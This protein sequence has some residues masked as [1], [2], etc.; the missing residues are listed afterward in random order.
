[1]SIASFPSSETFNARHLTSIQVAEA[2]IPPPQFEQLLN[3][4]N[5]LLV[6]ARGS[7]KTTLLKML[8]VQAL[9]KWKE[10]NGFDDFPVNFLGVFVP[11]DVRWSKQLSI[12]TQGITS[13]VERAVLYE[14][15]FAG[16]VCIALIDTL[17]QAL[18]CGAIRDDKK[19]IVQITREQEAYISRAL[20]LLWGVVTDI[21]SFQALKL[22]LRYS[23]A[24]LPKIAMSLK[25]GAGV[26][27]MLSENG[28]LGIGWLDALANA[29]EIINECAGCN[30]QKWALLV[31]ELEIV[32]D[33]LLGLIA[34]PLRSTT[35]NLVFKY[36]I[37]PTGTKSEII[38]S[39]DV[40]DPTP[41]NDFRIIR[42]W[43][44]DRD[45][46]RIF[47]SKMLTD[48]LVSRNLLGTDGDLSTALNRSKSA[49]HDD[50][51]EGK[52]SLEQK[53]QQFQ[54]LANKDPSFKKFV[55]SKKIDAAIFSTSDDTPIGPLIRKIAPLVYFRNFVLKSWVG[56]AERQIRNTKLSSQPYSGYPN[57]L[58]LT[59]GNPRWILNL[60][61]TLAAECLSRSSTLNQPGVQHAAIE[62]FARRFM[63]MLKVY[64]VGSDA[65]R[66]LTIYGFVE[67]L[68]QYLNQ[69]IYDKPFTA[70]PSLSFVIDESAARDFGDIIETCIHLGAL[71]IIDP[72]A[73]DDSSLLLGGRALE[74]RRV[75]L[76]YRLAPLFFLPLR[77]NKQIRLSSAFRQNEEQMHLVEMPDKVGRS[78]QD[79]D[80]NEQLDLF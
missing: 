35:G 76:C 32:P 44:T 45:Q 48:A 28:F 79:L 5:S 11:A 55:A 36:A 75:R 7:G 61:D 73:S 74:G 29:V 65:F 80:L 53:R 47:T 68:A 14:A 2:F 15:A 78:M 8:Q 40:S 23:Q 60:A 24:L 9:R 50:I 49:E 54:E 70:D 71:V 4:S 41:E 59:E 66:N 43:H 67:K 63:S 27:K 22:K 69:R 51:L 17:E 20:S 39:L 72:Q 38:S 33:E 37:S 18:R 56:G 6:G 57:L 10:I 46:I 62:S 16:S 77:A 3:N 34:S 31:D 30:S 12:K 26:D 21:P 42:L 13:S 64:P 25:N 52:L 1:M 58:D 19:Q